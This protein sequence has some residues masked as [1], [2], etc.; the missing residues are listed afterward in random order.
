MVI[1][2]LDHTRDFVGNVALNP[3]DVVRTH[4][5][6]FWTRWITHFCAPTFV[7]LAGASAYLF[8][9]RGRDTGEWSRFLLSRGLWLVFL[10]LTLIRL[11]WTFNLDYHWAWAQVIWVIGWALVLL[12]LMVKLPP[13]VVGSIGIAIIALHNLTDGLGRAQFGSLYWIWSLL[14]VT[15]FLHPAEGWFFLAAYP[16]IPWTGIALA[17]YGF[18]VVLQKQVADRRRIMLRTGLALTLGF[19]ALRYL[20]IYGDP[21]RWAVQNDAAHTL[22]SFLNTTKYGPS[23]LYTMM[24]LGPALIFLGLLQGHNLPPA[25]RWLVVFG[26]VPMFYYL[27]H[28]PLIH[29][30]AVAVAYFGY[31]QVGFLF[32]NP[33]SIFAGTLPDGWGL[34]LPWVYAVWALV[35]AILYPLCVWVARLKQRSS[36]RWLSYF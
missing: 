15:D 4:P 9:A 28:V 17:G 5:A 13:K 18:G 1:M 33:P 25:S 16:I 22:F 3:M 34:P 11:T 10:E 30:I 6:L 36:A 12:S 31:G 20:N 8:G 2:A 19:I 7:F 35:I 29:V 27:L 14:H 32:A 21:S 24:T 26:R 23:L